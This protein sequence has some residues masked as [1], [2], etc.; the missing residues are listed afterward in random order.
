MKSFEKV[1]DNALKVGHGVLIGVME[2]TPEKKEKAFNLLEYR[3]H[4]EKAIR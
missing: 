1:I 2:V 3:I 4:L